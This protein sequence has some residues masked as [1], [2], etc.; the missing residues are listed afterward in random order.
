MVVF[1]WGCGV[2]RIL[3]E[4]FIDRLNEARNVDLNRIPEDAVIDDVVAMNEMASRAG[5]V[6]SGNIRTA[7]LEVVRQSPH[8][9]AGNLNKTFKRRGCSPVG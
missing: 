9:L 5:D 8:P 4:Q 6:L 3:G 7:L 2:A 1:F